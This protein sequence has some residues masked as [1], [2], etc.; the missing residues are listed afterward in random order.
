MCYVI[1]AIEHLVVASLRYIMGTMF[2][3]GAL[4]DGDYSLEYYIHIMKDDDDDD[5]D[6]NTI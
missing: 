4:G 5:D 3:N 1:T 6:N 2:C